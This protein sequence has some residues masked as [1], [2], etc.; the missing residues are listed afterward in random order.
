MLPSYI[1]AISW[2]WA[3]IAGFGVA[4]LLGMKYKG[5]P[6]LPNFT[7]ILLL[8]CIIFM[9]EFLLLLLKCTRAV[10]LQLNAV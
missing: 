5:E 1:L 6:S 3:T 2:K 8:Q 10:V 9:E 4:L 7:L